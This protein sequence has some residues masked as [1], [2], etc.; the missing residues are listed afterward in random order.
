MFY[1]KRCSYQFR[2]IHRKTPVPDTFLNK[3]VGLGPY[4]RLWLKPK[5]YYFTEGWFVRSFIN[6]FEELFLKD[7]VTQDLERILFKKKLQH[8]FVP[9]NITNFLRTSVLKNICEQLLLTLQDLSKWDCFTV[10]LE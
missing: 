7:I 5:N 4:L 10:K 9:V 1:N 6:T 8:R 2:K 3:I